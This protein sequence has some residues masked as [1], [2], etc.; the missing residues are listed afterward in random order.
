MFKILSIIIT[1]AFLSLG[2]FLGILNPDT[3]K[4]DL[5]FRQIEIP[6]SILL[7]VTLSLGMLLAGIYFSLILMRKQWATRKLNKQ[8]LKL[9]NEI[10]QLNKRI[11]ELEK[12][13]IHQNKET[14]V[15]VLKD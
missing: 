2:I 9:S 12:T 14:N 10:V 4:F 15:P 7:A 5:I 11:S 1:L 8:N 3:V 6:L 13:S